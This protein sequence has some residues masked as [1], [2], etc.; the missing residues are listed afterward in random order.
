MQ[1]KWAKAVGLLLCLLLMASLA[2]CTPRSSAPEEEEAKKGNAFNYRHSNCRRRRTGL[3][4]AVQPLSTGQKWCPGK[5]AF[6]GGS[7]ALSG[8]IAATDANS[9]GQGY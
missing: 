8:G 3:A 7:T 2:A 5:L 9:S 6:T 4:A 1:R